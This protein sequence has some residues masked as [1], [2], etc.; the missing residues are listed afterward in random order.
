MK[1]LTKATQIKF[2]PMVERIPS[3]MRDAFKDDRL[4]LNTA[5]TP[6]GVPNTVLDIYSVRSGSKDKHNP[7]TQ[8]SVMFP[9]DL[10]EKRHIKNNR[11]GCP[12]TDSNVELVFHTW[13]LGQIKLNA[14]ARA[15]CEKILAEGIRQD[16]NAR[17]V[18]E[19]R[20]SG[21]VPNESYKEV[22]GAELVK[23]QKIP[24]H[25][26]IN[27]LD[28]A[29]F[30]QQGTGKTP[31]TISTVVNDCIRENKDD[32]Y[33]VIVVAPKNVRF[34]WE[35]EL[36]KFCPI[37]FKATVIRGSKINREKQLIEA[38]V[39]TNGERISFVICSYGTL[40]QSQNAFT[41][42][43]VT[44]FLFPEEL[45]WDYAVLDESHYIKSPSAKRT[46]SAH[47]LRDAS[48]KRVCLTGT[49]FVNSLF[50]LWAQWE[51][52]GKYRSGFSN[53]HAFKEFHAFYEKNHDG[54]KKVAQFDNVPLLQE[55]LARTSFIITKEEA[56]PDLPKKVYDV[57]EVGMSAE[58]LKIYEQVANQLYFEIENEF[59]E[60]RAMEVNNI[61]TKLL[62]L[63]QIT[64]GFVVF[65]P[66]YSDDGDLIEEQVIDRIDP[67][68][69]L[70]ALME[71]LR[72]KGSE[73]K[74]IIWT[75]WKQDIRTLSARMTEEGIKHVTFHGGTKDDDRRLAEE[76]FNCDPKYK[77]F[78]GNPQAGG[79][80]LNLLGYN[81]RSD[82]ISKEKTN[83]NHIIYY[84]QNWSLTAR[85]Q[86]EDRAHRRGTRSQ[87]RITDL[88]IP[89]SI[90]T[91]IRNRVMGKIKQSKHIQD[92]KHIFAKILHPI[93]EEA[94]D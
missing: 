49:P 44:G 28:Y 82:D 34:N 10:F 61:L 92:I 40:R 17:V 57:I 78:L 1:P 84:S 13:P 9:N 94:G 12:L 85:S 8:A 38:I 76:R 52:L 62:R 64:S 23:Y 31:T 29:L 67:N 60:V 53:F 51:F 50:D 66:I 15:Y 16:K 88:C 86:S 19:F 71:I 5:L 18:A 65:D 72:N 75:C 74:T 7:K 69:K 68:N 87:V 91:E 81:Y 42:K 11:Y 45:K 37:P 93:K 70:E 35:E 26:A 79:T 47:A 39:K 77:V 54:R 22:K 6:S 80:G 25:N 2:R 63:A 73:D 3:Y 89:A 59:K 56:L 41:L 27:S 83:C 48:K 55:R 32:L 46:K 90:D 14:L 24:R 36:K 20:D 30:M 58:Q 33:R 21:K 4:E 43:G